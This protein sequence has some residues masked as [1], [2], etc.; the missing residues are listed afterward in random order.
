MPPISMKIPMTS[1]NTGRNF[2]MIYS[3]CMPF[4]EE[5]NKVRATAM[6]NKWNMKWLV[7]YL[8]RIAFLSSTRKKSV[9]DS[10]QS[11]HKQ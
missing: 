9:S 10:W 3:R 4:E 7:K 5:T 2:L 11:Y 1:E 6:D 8:H